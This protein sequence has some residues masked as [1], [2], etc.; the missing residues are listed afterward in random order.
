MS[1]FENVTEQFRAGVQTAVIPSYNYTRW[2]I[3][4]MVLI[5]A[6][7]T[8]IAINAY[9]PAPMPQVAASAQPPSI[10][11]ELEAYKS[12]FGR[13]GPTHGERRLFVIG[14][15]GLP[16]TGDSNGSAIILD[17]PQEWDEWTM[18]KQMQWQLQ[19]Y[20]ELYGPLSEWE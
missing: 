13:G 14:E 8:L 16:G 12:K 15:G 19:Q 1:T 2:I 10:D 7:F 17:L 20:R 3:V 6:G 9:I 11:A 4:A 5:A 18:P